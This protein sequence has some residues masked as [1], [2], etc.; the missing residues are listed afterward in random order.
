MPFGLLLQIITQW[1]DQ[2][3]ASVRDET[4]VLLP[5]CVRPYLNGK[6]PVCSYSS[7]FTADGI[8]TG[9]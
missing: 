1:A 4:F 2:S 7:G 9:H 5:L 8:L 6:F 3:D